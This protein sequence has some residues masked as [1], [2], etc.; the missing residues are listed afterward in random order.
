MPTIATELKSFAENGNVKTY[1]APQHSVA[2]PRLVIQKRSIAASIASVAGTTLKVV[3]GTSDAAGAPIQQR[4]SLETVA[5]VPVSGSESDV[6]AAIAVFRDIVASDEFV[7]A[8]K[9]QLWVK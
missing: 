7:I 6:D 1:T 5:R 4:I 3:F 2:E 8:V 9:Q